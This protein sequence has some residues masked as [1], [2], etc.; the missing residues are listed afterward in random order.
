MHI[1][2]LRDYC[3]TKKGV[4]EHFPFDEVT[5][6]FKVMNKMFALT[7]L[8]SWEKGETKV[9]LKCD[10]DKSLELRGEYESINPGWHMNKKHWNTV[11]LNNDVSDDFAFQLIDHSYDLIVKGLTRKLQEELK[12]M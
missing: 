5:L 6:V 10:P 9:N 1:E 11:T 3:I 12:A 8:D 4:T 7:G 2:Q